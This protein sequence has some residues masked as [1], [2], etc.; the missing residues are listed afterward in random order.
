MLPPLDDE[1]EDELLDDDAYPVRDEPL[2]E[3]ADEVV[4]DPEYEYEG[5]RT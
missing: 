1:D 5:A 2:L 3:G 4:D